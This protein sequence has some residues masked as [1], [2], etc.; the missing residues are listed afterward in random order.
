MTSSEDKNVF[1]FLVSDDNEVLLIIHSR[2]NEPEEPAI[3]LM[4][5]NSSVEFF[6]DG[7][8]QLTLQNVK[9]EVFDALKDKTDI[10]VCEIESTE[11]PDETEIVYHYHAEIVKK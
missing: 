2:E 10:M 1:D 9:A 6:R 5:E 11:N 8:T 3:V 7:S 4:P